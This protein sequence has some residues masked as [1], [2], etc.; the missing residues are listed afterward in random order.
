MF[1][2]GGMGNIM[3]QAQKM[4]QRMQENMKKLEEELSHMKVTGESGAGMVKVVMNGNKNMCSL[5][6]DPSLIN[7]P[8]EKEMLEDLIVA[9]TNDA[10]RRAEELHQE[11]MGEITGNMGLPAGFKMPF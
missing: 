4:Q 2:K 6:I 10:Y 5:E 1:G 9:A 3:Q 7:D 11:K 8:D